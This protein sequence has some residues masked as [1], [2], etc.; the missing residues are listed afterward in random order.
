M[1]QEPASL[2]LQEI[3]D[4]WLSFACGNQDEVENI[5]A[6]G[7]VGV[8]VTRTKSPLDMCGTCERSTV[9]SHSICVC[10]IFRSL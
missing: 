5:L 2:N 4:S 7:D 3:A 6:A 9:V 10:V 1:N 8:T